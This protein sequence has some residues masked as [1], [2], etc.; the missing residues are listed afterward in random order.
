MFQVHTVFMC[1]IVNIADSQP[2]PYHFCALQPRLQPPAPKFLYKKISLPSSLLS[3]QASQKWQKISTS[4]VQL[5]N[6]YWLVDTFSSSPGL[7]VGLLRCMSF[8]H[9]HPEVSS[10]ISTQLPTEA[11]C[12]W[13]HKSDNSRHRNFLLIILKAT[14]RK[15]KNRLESFQIIRINTCTYTTN[16]KIKIRNS[17]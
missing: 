10:R 5:S 1:Y 4:Q 2:H 8:S 9:W 13:S 3:A 12:S 16:P 7:Q 11:I 6:K 15:E 17:Y 14:T